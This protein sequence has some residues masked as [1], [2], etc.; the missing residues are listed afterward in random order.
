[1]ALPE[2]LMEAVRRRE[3]PRT[4]FTGAPA[5]PPPLM[6]R[7]DAPPQLPPPMM[8]P[9]SELTPAAP[10]GLDLVPRGEAMRR[11][12]AMS[13]QGVAQAQPV[14]PMERARQQDAVLAAIRELI[15]RS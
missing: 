13:G 7:P 14:D 6:P 5:A 12:L 8:P 15:R 11:Q 4:G 3:G 1:M 9:P 10:Y 2:Y